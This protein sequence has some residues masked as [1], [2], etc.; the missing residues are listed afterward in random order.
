MPDR[1]ANSV[2]RLDIVSGGQTGVDQGALA[3]ALDAHVRCG[4]W[5][6]AGR[7]SEE[8]PI[9]ARF[10]VKELEGADYKERTRQNVIDSDGTA[11]VYF[12]TLE[13]GTALTVTCCRQA[14]KPFVLIDTASLSVD[15]A[16]ADLRAF[17]REHGIQVLNVAG[18]RRSKWTG[19][20][21]AAYGLVAALLRR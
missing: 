5:C 7:R 17:V 6:P 13:G 9:P 10:P 19:A 21:D 16:V 11:L 2:D 12:E 20:F 4:G 15:Q 14:R 3:A 18:P 8:G 1:P